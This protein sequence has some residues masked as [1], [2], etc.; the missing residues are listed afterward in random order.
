MD[1]SKEIKDNPILL[2]LVPK[3]DYKAG[4]MQV[5]KVM[6][7]LF[8]KTLIILASKPY[9]T[10]KKEMEAESISLE[11]FSFIDTLTST[12]IKPPTVKNCKFVSSPGD[13]T[14]LSVSFSGM[15]KSCNA[16]LIDSIS[17]LLIYSDSKDVTRLV[18]SMVT[19]ARTMEKNLVIV[20]GK[21]DAESPLIKELHVFASKVVNLV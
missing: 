12:V 5:S 20:A 15:I 6:K 2:V 10:I 18:H 14:D 17:T 13:L 4:L 19:K 9:A 11:K 1:I 21:E 7:S 3:E 16:A 8:S